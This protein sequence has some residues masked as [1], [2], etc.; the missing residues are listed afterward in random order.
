MDVCIEIKEIGATATRAEII[1]NHTDVVNMHMTISVGLFSDAGD[2]LKTVSVDHQL[3]GFPIPSP[4]EQ[5]EI[6]RPVIE[7]MQTQAP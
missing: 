3:T 5:W 7:S 2:L 4:D 1:D 6:V